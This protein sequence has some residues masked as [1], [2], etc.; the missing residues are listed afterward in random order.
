MYVLSINELSAS[1]VIFLI[2]TIKFPYSAKCIDL[3]SISMETMSRVLYGPLD[4]NKN[5][6]CIIFEE[7]IIASLG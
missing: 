5:Q 1:A 7:K 3:S 6:I 4:F 2:D